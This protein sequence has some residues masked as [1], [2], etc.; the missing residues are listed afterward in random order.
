[1]T[2][3]ALAVAFVQ[4][5]T[6]TPTGPFPGPIG[7]RVAPP[8]N[9]Y[10]RY[11]AAGAR[12]PIGVA[13]EPVRIVRSLVPVSITFHGYAFDGSGAAAP[14]VSMTFTLPGGPACTATTDASG[15]ATCATSPV[16]GILLE[17]VPDY[18]ITA[19]PSVGFLATNATGGIVWS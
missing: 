5:V 15:A 12:L 9:D 10:L 1:M 17:A 4:T 7:V 16:P 18:R 13:G 3:C 6:A 19:L 2:T 14:G 11:G 8:P